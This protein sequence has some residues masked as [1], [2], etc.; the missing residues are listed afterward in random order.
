MDAR[1]IMDILSDQ[2]QMRSRILDDP[3]IIDRENLDR[4]E[5]IKGTD[6]ISVALGAR[7]SGKTVFSNLLFRGLEFGY[8]NFDDERLAYIGPEDLNMILEAL[9]QIHGELEYLILDEIQNIN[10]WELFVNRLQ[11]TG[12]RT[13]VTGSNANLLSQELATHL[14]GRHLKME[15]FPF[16]FREFLL[17]RGMEERP[18][19]TK[20]RANIKKALEEYMRIGGF[21]EVV[22]NVGIKDLYLNSLYSSIINKDILARYNLRY[23]KTFKEM[24]VSLVSNHSTLITYNRLARV[25]GLK[26]VHTVKNYIDHLCGSY[27]LILLEKHSYKPQEKHN[28]PKKVYVIDPGLINVI[29][30]FSSENSGRLMENIVMLDLL[31][32]RS[33][34]PKLELYYWKDY[35]QK[36]VDFVLKRGTGVDELIQVTH[37]SS[38]SDI[39]KREL[40]ALFRASDELKCEDLKV[41]T[42]DLTDTEKSGGKRIEFIPLWRWL[43]GRR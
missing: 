38:R 21:P 42:W 40:D 41:I 31:R 1:T 4:W 26:S 8:V 5:S 17:C 2:Q 37:V 32:T 30:S 34:D 3:G 19:T 12:I 25:H 10:G 15:I 23:I 29:G 36:E 14:T 11:R 24:A 43:L 13:I 33:M 16:S 18:S 22:R 9:Y 7:R 35:Q 39:R 6:L 27:L 28:S 20:G